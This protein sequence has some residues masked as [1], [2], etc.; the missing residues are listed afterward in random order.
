MLFRSDVMDTF[1]G[2][3]S[4]FGVN[5]GVQLMA[6]SMKKREVSLCMDRFLTAFGIGIKSLNKI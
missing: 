6:C 5:N 2:N 1:R 3:F 4:I